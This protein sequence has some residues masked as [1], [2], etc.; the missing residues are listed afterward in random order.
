MK[1]LGTPHEILLQYLSRTEAEGHGDEGVVETLPKEQIQKENKRR[2][3][4]SDIKANPKDQSKPA[5]SLYVRRP[6]SHRIGT[7]VPIK[8]YN[9][10]HRTEANSNDLFIN[11]IQSS[12]RS[13]SV[14]LSSSTSFAVGRHQSHEGVEAEPKL[15]KP[16]TVQ[17]PANNTEV[18]TAGFTSENAEDAKAIRLSKSSDLKTLQ[19]GENK[20]VT[21]VASVHSI[22]NKSA[23]NPIA[24]VV[25]KDEM[26][27]SFDVFLN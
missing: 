18:Q 1:V 13:P 10:A 25:T 19:D 12:V 15:D 8:F 24:I 20:S 23:T 5:T 9:P 17:F 11:A 22:F 16:L 7:S 26:R 3:I 6:H 2:T 27:I 14:P 4:V 21:S